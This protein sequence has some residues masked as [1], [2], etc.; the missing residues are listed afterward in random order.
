MADRRDFSYIDLRLDQKNPRHDPVMTQRE[1]IVALL[2]DSTDRD[3]IVTLAKHMTQ[4]GP[5]PIDSIAVVEEEGHNIVIEGNRRTAALKLLHNPDL[6][7]DATLAK[8]F[9]QMAAAA[10]ALPTT[11]QAV[12]FPSREDVREWQVLRHGGEAKGAGVVNWNAEATQRFHRRPG[13][14]SSRSLVVLD[15]IDSAFSSDKAMTDLTDRVKKTKLT[16]FGRLVSDPYV[17]EALGIDL[18]EGALT[19]HYP[20]DELK[21]AFKK[22]LSDLDTTLSV[23][24]LKTK[25]QRREYVGNIRSELPEEKDY[26]ATA[27]PF[28]QEAT[29]ETRRSKTKKPVPAKLFDGFV[30]ANAPDRILD[31]VT[32]TRKLDLAAHPNAAALLIR[33]IVEL[34]VDEAVQKQQWRKSQYLRDRIEECLKHLDPKDKDNRFQAVRVGLADQNHIMSARTLNA[35]VHNVHFNPPPKDLEMLAKNWTPFIQALDAYV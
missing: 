31:L 28:G 1:A 27:E 21:R 5:S 12:V 19:R 8:R 30:P 18:A 6:S 7:Q 2:A 4:N 33:V 25:E 17:R 11:L 32:E 24:A 15:A 13:T 23:S 16:T 35:W 34:M 9:R 10:D 20:I 29:P 3:K 26:S 22:V 14:Q